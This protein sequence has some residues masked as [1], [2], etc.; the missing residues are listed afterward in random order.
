[1][2]PQTEKRAAF[3]ESEHRARLARLRR[4]LRDEGLDAMVSFSPEHIYYFTGYDGHTQFSI[5]SV[6]VGADDDEATLILRDVD[7]INAEETCWAKDIR[8]YHHGQHDPAELIV[9]AARERLRSAGVLGTCLN[10]YA[11]PGAFALHLVDLLGSSRTRDAGAAI[12]RLRYVK[13]DLE[14][15]Y[16]RQAAKYADIGLERLRAAAKPGITEIQLT[17]E[18]EAAMR[19][20]GS[21]YPAM[22]TLLSSGPRTRGS[23]RTPTDRVIARGDSIKTEFPGIARRYHAVTMQTLWIGEPGRESRQSYEHALTA[24]RAGSGEIVVGVPVARAELAALESLKSAGLDVSRHARF[25]YGVSAAYPPSWLEGLDI[26]AE[27]TEVF[28]SN[29]TFVLHCMV[30]T[31]DGRGILIGGAYTLGADGV[32]VLSGGDLELTVV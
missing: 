17:G 3:P 5:Q 22:P 11:L 13:S 15:T 28:Q 27:S 23:H 7:A 19:E 9:A 20:A 29:M 16:I 30:R 21:E 6:I 26:T 10:T 24:L 31:P 4:V 18:I 8:Y 25:G 2:Q 32:E 14:M 12:E 1:M